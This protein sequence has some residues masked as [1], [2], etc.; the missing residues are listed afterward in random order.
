MSCTSNLVSWSL[1]FLAFSLM[2]CIACIPWEWSKNFFFMNVLF[3]YNSSINFV[4]SNSPSSISYIEMSRSYVYHVR[5]SFSMAHQCKMK[6][7]YIRATHK[8]LDAWHSFSSLPA[9][10]IRD[11]KRSNCRIIQSASIDHWHERADKFSMCIYIQSFWIS[12]WALTIA[13]IWPADDWTANSD[14]CYQIFS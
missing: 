11:S 14:I 9:S 7:E 12:I 5:K 3:E 2:A 10:G 13:I 6:W 8:W 4:L 1:Y